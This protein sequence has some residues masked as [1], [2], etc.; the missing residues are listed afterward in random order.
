MEAGLLTKRIAIDTLEET[1]DEIVA[2]A[3]EA[4]IERIEKE[5]GTFDFERFLGLKDE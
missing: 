4:E 2:L 1:Y 5:G 3:T